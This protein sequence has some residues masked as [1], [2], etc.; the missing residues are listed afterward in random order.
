MSFAVCM[1]VSFLGLILRRIVTFG[2]TCIS[3]CLCCSCCIDKVV[4]AP[5][6]PDWSLILPRD[7]S[8]PST[9]AH[10][11][12]VPPSR[13]AQATGAAV[14]AVAAVAATLAEEKTT[15]TKVRNKPA[16]VWQRLLDTPAAPPS[17]APDA[18][19][20]VQPMIWVLR[21]R[22]AHFF[23]TCFN[24]SYVLG[25]FRMSRVQYFNGW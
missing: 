12:T 9:R 13:P 19:P 4:V 18:A 10:A 24:V 25:F 21:D 20:L 8:V 11:Q 17:L 23:F 6:Q 14:T 15:A 5:F 3:L 1:C 2:C 7:S 22:Q 16:L